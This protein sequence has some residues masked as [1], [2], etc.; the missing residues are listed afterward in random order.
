MNHSTFLELW[1]SMDPVPLQNIDEFEYLVNEVEKLNPKRILEIGILHG[2]T[3]KFFSY[4]NP[5]FTIAIDPEP[6]L[7]YEIPNLHLITSKSQELNAIREVEQ[8]L[9]GQPLD[10]IMI[11]GNH[12]YD[13]AKADFDNYRGFVRQ[14]GII[15]FHDTYT[16]WD[17]CGKFFQELHIQY[18]DKTEDV[19]LSGGQGTGIY[20]V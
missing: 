13:Y 16:E 9:K 20:R 5:E 11:D 10:F 17:K 15:A 6:Q 3:A 18:P 19:H 14:G 8:F 7:K 4:L 2:A 12:E 1:N